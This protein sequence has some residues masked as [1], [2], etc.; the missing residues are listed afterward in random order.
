MKKNILSFFP[1][2]VID[3]I[4]LKQVPIE[5]L[6]NMHTL[7]FQRFGQFFLFFFFWYL[8]VP[9]F[10]DFNVGPAYVTVRFI[11]LRLEHKST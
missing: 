5:C 1:Y 4:L 9:Y 3:T 11:L 8:N 2:T 10:L 6:H 7:F